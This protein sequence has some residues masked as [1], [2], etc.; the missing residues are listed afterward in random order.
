MKMLYL[1]RLRLMVIRILSLHVWGLLPDYTQRSL[2]RLYAGLFE[3]ATSKHLIRIYC[4]L[5]KLDQKYL[6]R[7]VPASGKNEYQN[8]QDF[9]SR[10]LAEPL[11]VTSKKCWPCEGLLCEYGKIVNLPF[12][13]V[14]G[15]IQPLKEIFGTGGTNI[16]ENYYFSNVFLHNSNYHRIHSPVSGTITRIERISGRLIILRPW[17]YKEK[18][19]LPALI[20]ERVNVDIVSDRGERWFISIVGGPAVGTIS[21]ASGAK[22]SET[23]K[24]GSELALFSLGSTCCI[25]SPEPLTCSKIGQQI[26]VGASFE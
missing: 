21:M 5:Q 22:V 20:N 4:I 14:K 8:F 25:A 10:S 23:I 24:I 7:F 15:K 2:S 19:S 12:V 11:R 1:N 13:K 6:E 26:Q 9:F 3:M 16:P 17:I 18:P